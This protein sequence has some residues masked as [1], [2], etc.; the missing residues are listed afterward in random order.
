MP[1]LRSG[2]LS[3]TVIQAT[4]IP[5]SILRHRQL[6]T[7]ASDD[8]GRSHDHHDE[9]LKHSSHNHLYSYSSHDEEKEGHWHVAIPAQQVRGIYA[10]LTVAFSTVWLAVSASVT[11]SRVRR[12]RAPASA[13]NSA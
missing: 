1:P 12:S 6:I 7:A 9:H 3:G 4:I 13:A 11:I 10:V 5:I 8:H 2:S